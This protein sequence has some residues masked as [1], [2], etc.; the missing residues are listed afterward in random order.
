VVDGCVPDGFAAG[1]PVVSVP[2]EPLDPG[3]VDVPLVLLPGVG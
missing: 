3:V 1:W 2:V